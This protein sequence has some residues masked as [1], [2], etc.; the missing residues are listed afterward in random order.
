MHC[1]SVQRSYVG[2]EHLGHALHQGFAA[3]LRLYSQVTD[4]AWR[5][6]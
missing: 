3:L 5:H 2:V 1:Y 4:M 6:A